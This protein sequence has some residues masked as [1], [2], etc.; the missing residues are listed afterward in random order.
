[1][2]VWMSINEL[3]K[4]KRGHQQ[5]RVWLVVAWRSVRNLTLEESKSSPN[6]YS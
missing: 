2:T 4:A 1:M 6:V 3:P 5:L